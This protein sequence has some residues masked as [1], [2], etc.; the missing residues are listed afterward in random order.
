MS[1]MLR[2]SPVICAVDT[3]TYI[4]GFCYYSCR[5]GFREAYR[6]LVHLRFPAAQQDGEREDAT[7]LRRTSIPRLITFVVTMAQ[8]SRLYAFSGC[9]G[10][11]CVVSAYLASFVLTELLTIKIYLPARDPE[12]EALVS[13]QTRESLLF[14]SYTFFLW[15]FGKSLDDTLQWP[16]LA[17]LRQNDAL[18]TVIAINCVCILGG[19]YAVIRAIP[20]GQA[21]K[22][23]RALVPWL[24][25]FVIGVLEAAFIIASKR[26]F[27]IQD[28]RVVATSACS[29]VVP[30]II[31]LPT[32]VIQA[33]RRLRSW[34][35]VIL[36]FVAAVLY[37]KFSYDPEGSYA[38][39]WTSFL[40]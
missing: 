10:T 34:F 6:I 31:I 9:V 3:L 13:D 4:F 39:A 16:L 8:T 17:I 15:V 32:I 12:R 28:W 38:P 20:R 1:F 5:F 22:H 25:L 35:F 26:S 27:S 7:S 21:Y 19:A 40:G 36:H 29:I 23:I 37:Y 24:G 30:A 2:A 11:K 33:L 14:I 18:L